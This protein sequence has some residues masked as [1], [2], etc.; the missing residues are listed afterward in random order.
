[1]HADTTGVILTGHSLGALLAEVCAAECGLKAI[2]FESPGCL[3]ILRE[4][5]E[6]HL[7]ESEVCE[8]HLLLSGRS[9]MLSLLVAS[10]TSAFDILT[11]MQ[12]K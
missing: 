10:A 3:P 9:L 8:T 7:A 5:V 12:E 4:R 1:M 6:Y 2:T 11:T